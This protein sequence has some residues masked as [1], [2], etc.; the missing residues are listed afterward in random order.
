[1][2]HPNLNTAEVMPKRRDRAQ[3]GPPIAKVELSP[4]DLLALE[5]V[6]R[7]YRSNQARTGAVQIDRGCLDALAN[8]LADTRA[9]T[10]FKLAK[11]EDM[12]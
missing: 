9:V 11:P 1:M 12:I 2:T 8:R 6:I 4:W 7:W 5:W 3:N 10:P